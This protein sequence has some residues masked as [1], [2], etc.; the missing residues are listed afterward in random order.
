[1]RLIL[2][3]LAKDLVRIRVYALALLGLA[4]M[5]PTLGLLVLHAPDPWSREDARWFELADDFLLMGQVVGAWLLS[6]WLVQ[7]DAPRRATAF[8]HT[9]PVS[10][11]VLCTAKLCAAW[12]SGAVAPTLVLVPWW[13]FGAPRLDQLLAVSL[14]YVTG[15]SLAVLAALVIGSA[16]DNYRRAVLWSVVAAVVAMCAPLLLRD[17]EGFGSTTPGQET[18]HQVLWRLGAWCAWGTV[19]GLILLALLYRRQL[20]W[21]GFILAGAGLGLAAY[22]LHH[23]RWPDYSPFAGPNR[24]NAS[25]GDLKVNV[26]RFEHRWGISPV[27]SF[28]GLGEHSVMGY[29]TQTTIT[30][31]RGQ[32]FS[33]E[34]EFFNLGVYH[35][36]HRPIGHSINGETAK[37]PVEEVTH[38]NAFF[39]WPSD[40]AREVAN[41]LTPPLRLQCDLHLELYHSEVLNVRYL[42]D[43]RWTFLTNYGASRLSPLRESQGYWM[44][45]EVRASLSVSGPWM[46]GFPFLARPTLGSFTGIGNNHSTLLLLDT[47]ALDAP[48]N[49]DKNVGQRAAFV[50]IAGLRLE[51][52]AI[53]VKRVPNTHV[54]K[55][56]LVAV[57]YRPVARFTHPI[58]TPGLEIS[59]GR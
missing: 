12:L 48:D 17:V 20:K 39:N 51:Q 43:R 40:D 26:T 58:D 18:V 23:T 21:R 42:D 7:L 11:F 38:V 52:R 54:D 55:F 1:M 50:T 44:L 10:R 35:L 3:L 32:K 53:S 24:A 59:G 56:R 22:S 36:N 8:L 31:S 27:F 19:A 33:R 46:L 9:R 57:H 4:T 34:G 30:D 6:L 15:L 13:I 41:G 47:R 5:R 29:A 2:H 28:A 49:R 37:T 14:T 45:D 25:A 16:V